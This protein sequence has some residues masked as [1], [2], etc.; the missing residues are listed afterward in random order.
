M[1]W[2]G[3]WQGCI[4]LLMTA[5]L[6]FGTPGKDAFHRVPLFVGEI[7]DAVERV[8]TSQNRE[9]D[10]AL[11]AWRTCAR[12]W[13]SPIDLLVSFGACLKRRLDRVGKGLEF[14]HRFHGWHR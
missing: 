2:F 12:P 5:P 6:G 4:K 10:A 13:Q 1:L 8:L 7:G 9:L 3:A 14:C 11:G